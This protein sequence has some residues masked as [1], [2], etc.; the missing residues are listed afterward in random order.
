MDL[1]SPS[2]RAPEVFHDPATKLPEADNN[3]RNLGLEVEH[4]PTGTL[5]E[6]GI[7]E[8]LELITD[9]AE[10][11]KRDQANKKQSFWARIRLVF[12]AVAGL[13]IGAA[14]AGGV[15]DSIAKK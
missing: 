13:S 6:I 4:D 14:V 5:P 15:T 8:G 7:E 9:N 11:E 3:P 1:E 10:T 2:S 12:V